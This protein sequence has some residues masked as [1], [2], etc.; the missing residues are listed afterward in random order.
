LV[1]VIGAHGFL[2]VPA[3]R[4]PSVALRKDVF[5]EAL[6]A[7]TTIFLLGDFKN[8]FAHVAKISAT[9]LVLT[10]SKSKEEQS[11]IIGDEQE[12]PRNG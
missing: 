7:K 12:L 3:H 2:D 5:R 6:G 10:S 9:Q 1:E 4:L 11:P 8:Q